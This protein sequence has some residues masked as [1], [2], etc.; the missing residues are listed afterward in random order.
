VA[1]QTNKEIVVADFPDANCKRGAEFPLDI[2]YVRLS[3]KL[4]LNPVYAAGAT[5]ARAWMNAAR[6]MRGRK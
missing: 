6:K 3:K 5:P 4:T 2:F 1:R